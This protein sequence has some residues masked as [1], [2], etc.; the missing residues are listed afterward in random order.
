MEGMFPL[1]EIR[2][3]HHQLY[4]MSHYIETGG[5]IRNISGLAGERFLSQ[6]KKCVKKGGQSFE[7]TAISNFSGYEISKTK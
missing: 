6:I 1:S 3:P 2:L 7:M 5:A 4:C